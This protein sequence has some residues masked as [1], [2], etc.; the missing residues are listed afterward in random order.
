M[1]KDK[2]FIDKLQNVVGFCK[3][4][5]NRNMKVCE[6]KAVFVPRKGSCENFLSKKK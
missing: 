5:D 3:D 2:R 6:R 1:K 4:C